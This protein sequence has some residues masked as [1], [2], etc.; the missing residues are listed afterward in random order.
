MLTTDVFQKYSEVDL[1]RYRPVRIKNQITHLEAGYSKQELIQWYLKILRIIWSSK[2]FVITFD[3]F[4]LATTK[5][6][7]QRRIA[8]CSMQFITYFFQN[9]IK[10]IVLS[11][12]L[13]QNRKTD[14][15]VQCLLTFNFCPL[16]C[17]DL[18]A[19]RKCFDIF[20]ISS[21]CVFHPL[22]SDSSSFFSRA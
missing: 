11:I 19:L 17:V 16:K 10:I 1:S 9:K 3:M 4:A 5:Y 13:F 7:S 12:D 15:K 2:S 20:S 14:S 8:R 22:Y 18:Y 6:L 21:H